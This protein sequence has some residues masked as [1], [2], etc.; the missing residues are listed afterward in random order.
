VN[1]N[2]LLREFQILIAQAVG[3]AVEAEFDL[4]PALWPCRVDPA[5]FQSAVLNLAV[6]ARDAMPGGGRLTIATRNVDLG[7]AEIARLPELMSG[8]YVMV[9]VTDTGEGIAPDI[10]DRIFEPFF[11]TKDIGKGTGLGLS[12]VYGFVQQS[13]G[14]IA[15]E[16]QAGGGATFRI[17]LPRAPDAKAVADARQSTAAEVLGGTETI[18][19]AED[20]TDVLDFVLTSLASLGY[21]TL[22]ARNG[23]EALDVLRREGDRVDLVFTD[24]AMPQGMSGVELA[25]EARRLRPGIK[26]L[27]TSGY[28]AND[29][30]VFDGSD[31]EFPVLGK[32]YRHEDLAEK[33]RATLDEGAMS[34]P[35]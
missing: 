25:R 28:A 24:V 6:N 8:P 14:A 34:D 13:G 30:L 2:E 23:H 1:L 9:S 10:V 16:S 4:D 18:L 12:Q 32:P 5:Q 31:E 3:E 29:R 21:R 11:T 19:V 22:T 35:S 7:A 26:V 15:V 33:I 27:L 20:D 17:F